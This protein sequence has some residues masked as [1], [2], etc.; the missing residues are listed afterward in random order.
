MSEAL[1]QAQRY[2]YLAKECWRLATL[3]VSTETRKHYREMAE[4][5][6]ALADAEELSTPLHASGE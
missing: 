4:H 5:Y 2:R 1:K 6:S 3:D